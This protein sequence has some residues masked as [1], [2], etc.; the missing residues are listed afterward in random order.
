MEP[1]FWK[2]GQRTEPLIALVLFAVFSASAIG[3]P[4]EDSV[5]AYENQEYDKAY[6]LLLPLAEKSDPKAELRLGRIC[7]CGL[8]CGSF[9]HA[10]IDAAK[11]LNLAA[12]HGE[13]DAQKLLSA[14]EPEPNLVLCFGLPDSDLCKAPKAPRIEVPKEVPTEDRWASACIGW[15]LNKACLRLNICWHCI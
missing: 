10:E 7:L 6:S 9:W 12:Q 4:Y 3:G 1:I 14:K 2:F 5:A 8:G 15:P 11:W 13:A